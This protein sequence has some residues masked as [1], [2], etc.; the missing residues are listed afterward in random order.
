MKKILCIIVLSYLFT[1]H[2]VFAV[3]LTP[4]PTNPA[5]T[6]AIDD[7]KERLAT[8]VAELRQTQ[9]KA[10]SG[11]VKEVTVST[12]TIETSGSDIKIE[13]TDDIKVFQTIKGKRTALTTDDIAKSDYVAVIGN[14]DT[15]LDLLYA[16]VVVIQNAPL[17]RVAGMVSEIDRTEFTATVK[18]P[19]GQ[20]YVIDIEKSTGALIFDQT[21][22]LIKGGFSK[23]AIGNTVHI[24]GT[25]VPKKENRVS[26]VRLIDLGNLNSVTPTPTPEVTSTASASGTPKTTPKA[27]VK[28]SSTATP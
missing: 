9:R 4:S 19:D 27:T 2:A 25:V 3:T 22:G 1:S 11:V 5:P 17:F 13:L 12:F 6:T 26:A 16:K 23:L 7:L 20:E 15:G 21:R 24:V 10:I 18:T 8:K 14:L 28:P